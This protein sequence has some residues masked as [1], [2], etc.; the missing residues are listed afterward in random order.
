MLK[1]KVT[2]YNNDQVRKV[3][4]DFL[5]LE[6]IYTR[7]FVDEELGHRETDE[8]EIIYDNMEQLIIQVL[9]LIKEEGFR[10]Y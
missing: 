1:E 6:N 2:I 7:R 10:F 4:E 8:K 9:E 3:L 5:K